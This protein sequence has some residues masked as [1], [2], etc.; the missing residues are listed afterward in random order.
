MLD[1]GSGG[2]DVARALS[3]W[4]T[5]DGYQLTVTAIDPDERA[6]NWAKAQPSVSG[7]T[8]KRCTSRELV[9]EG[10]RYDL[11]ISNHLLH[12]L[13]SDQ[14]SALL[15][16]SEQLALVRVVHNDIERNLWA[17]LLFSLGTWPFFPGSFIREDGLTSIRRSYTSKELLAVLP[18]EWRL[19]RQ[20]PWRNLLLHD[21]PGTRQ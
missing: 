7:L 19:D 6:H 13:D 1:I 11:V 2:G 8:F 21:P 9:T 12:H 14:F 16:D 10:H 4:A 20:R 3:K 15:L 17:Y 5:R 18:P